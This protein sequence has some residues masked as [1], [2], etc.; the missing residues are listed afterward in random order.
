MPNA[1]LA[2]VDGARHALPVECPDRFN[3]LVGDFLRRVDDGAR[4]GASKESVAA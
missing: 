3:E 1:E 4:V 2:V